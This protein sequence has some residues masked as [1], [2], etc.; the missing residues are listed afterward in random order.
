MN[1]NIL[2]LEPKALWKNFRDLTLIPRP[3]KHEKKVTDFL[4]DF[5]KKH[6]DEAFIDNVGNVVFRKKSTISMA[7]RKGI[8]L[9]AHCDMVPQKDDNKVHN[10]ETDPIETIVTDGF[11]MANK[12][13]LGADDGMGVAAIM[14]IMQDENLQH[15]PLEALIT[16]DEETG[17]TGA[18]GLEP[19]L[20]KSDVLLNLDSEE[21]NIFYIGCAGGITANIEANLTFEDVYDGFTPYIINVDGFLGGHSGSDIHKNRPNAIKILFRLFM[22]AENFDIKICNFEGGSLSNAIPRS[23]KAQILVDSSKIS[24]FESFVTN[25]NK[26]IYREYSN[27]DPNGK[28]SFIK[29][30]SLPSKC[31]SDDS[32]KRIIFLV[33]SI[34]SGVFTMSAD[35]PGLVETS[36]NLAIVKIENSKALITT[37]LRSSVDSQSKYLCNII[38]C[39]VEYCGA[40]ISFS[41]E[42]PGWKPNTQSE[43]MEIMKSIYKENFGEEPIITAIHAGLECGLILGKYPKL[44]VISF[45]PNLFNVHTPTE[46]VEIKSV[47][48][49]M[50]LLYEVIKNAPFKGGLIA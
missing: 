18:F 12:T 37:L 40:K 19:N 25:F 14:T 48:K 39:Q 42:Y 46:K 35:I 4:L 29:Q 2:S 3:S 22:E 30:D 23:C 44:D 47:Q 26:T 43:I 31:L 21:D 20:L 17:L 9:Q 16:I 15:G 10:F 45:G 28:I 6:C 1:E 50:K 38:K 8:L 34:V 11:V 41:G 5:G 33:N 13:T 24:E 27:F 7:N 32:S 49:I 36:N